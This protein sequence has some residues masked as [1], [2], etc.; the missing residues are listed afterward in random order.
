MQGEAQ[1]NDEQYA[2]EI[3]MD[4]YQHFQHDHL[5]NDS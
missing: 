5:C 2:P 4:F 1:G 3:G